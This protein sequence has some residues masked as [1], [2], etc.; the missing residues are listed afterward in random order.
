MNLEKR[1]KLRHLKAFCEIAR[2][3]SFKKAA[4]AL[5]VTQPAI[6]RTL[7]ELEQMVE[8]TLLIRD[9]GGVALTPEGAV[10][11]Q[12]AQMGL[13]AIQQGVNRLSRL[14]S[15]DAGRVRVGALPSVAAR[16]LPDAVQA[17]AHLSPGTAV[18]V[19]EGPHEFLVN[20]LKAG[21][22]DLVAGRLGTPETMA[23]LSFTQLYLEHV[24]FAARPGHPLAG[25][26]DMSAIGDYPIIYP[27]QNAAIR[28]LVDRLMIAGGVSDPPRTIE[29]VSGSFGRSLVLSSDAVWIISAG[30]VAQDLEA[31]RLISLDIDTQMTSGPV[32][33]MMR[34][35]EQSP[36]LVQLFSRAVGQVLEARR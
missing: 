21:E 1:I 17:F 30:V 12:F 20:R 11:L 18:M 35:D 25:T 22:L 6:S 3:G 19:E 31:G 8:A 13:D 10:F 4:S 29:S 23:G 14:R 33:I 7:A 9:R 24:V 32:G 27:A 34:A 28:P 2:L 16:L 36:V 26:A 15:G 5:H